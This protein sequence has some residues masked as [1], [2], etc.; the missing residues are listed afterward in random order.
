MMLNPRRQLY[1]NSNEKLEH[2]NTVMVKL[3]KHPKRT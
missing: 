1:H 3:I 2:L